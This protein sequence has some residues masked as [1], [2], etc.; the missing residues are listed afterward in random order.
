MTIY[1]SK[2]FFHHLCNGGGVYLTFDKMNHIE[3]RN[4]E[5]MRLERELK[6]EI[7][8]RQLS[9]LIAI[10]ST[11]TFLVSLTAYLISLTNQ[12]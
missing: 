9:D 12:L 4:A 8:N 5:I 11:A 6:I 10:A 7:K 3:K 1:P 2:T